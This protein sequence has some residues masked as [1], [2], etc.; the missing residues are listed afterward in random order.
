[1]IL[2]AISILVCGVIAF[3]CAPT[4]KETGSQNTIEL[5]V[6][7]EDDDEPTMKIAYSMDDIRHVEIIPKKLQIEP[8]QPVQLFLAGTLPDKTQGRIPS[9]VQWSVTN[10]ALA[11]VGKTSGEMIARAEGKVTVVAKFR[12]LTD[13]RTIDVRWLSNVRRQLPEPEEVTGSSVDENIVQLSWAFGDGPVTGH[14]LAYRKGEA[15][16][17]CEQQSGQNETSYVLAADIY[18]LTEVTVMGLDEMTTYGFR[19]CSVQ[20]LDIEGEIVRRFS[21]GVVIS[22]KTKKASDDVQED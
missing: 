16:S 14:Q 3:G 21:K 8:W 10:D 11:L 18:D 6:S 12:G 19:L 17:T 15:P 22:I 7:P 2:R 9:E 4:Q 5:P 13:K 1:M 20:E